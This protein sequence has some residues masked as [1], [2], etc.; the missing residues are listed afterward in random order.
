MGFN[1]AECDVEHANFC[2]SLAPTEGVYHA[3][4]SLL[5]ISR[6]MLLLWADVNIPPNWVVDLDVFVQNVC[7][8]STFPGCNDCV[9]VST[10]ILLDVDCFEGAVE[11]HIC[12]RD[13]FDAGEV[14]SGGNCAN[15]HPNSINNLNVSHHNIFSALSDSTSV[16]HRL[17]SYS[18]IEIGN[19]DAFN[20]EVLSRRVNTISVK[21]ESWDLGQSNRAVEEFV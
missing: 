9:S 3:T 6:L 21:W 15:C 16:V 17:N 7:N 5:M 8:D 13:V 10:R 20:Q 2:D 4:E 14:R 12:E 18:V 1:V 11:S 19:L